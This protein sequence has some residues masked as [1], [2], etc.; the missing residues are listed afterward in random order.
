MQEA[1]NALGNEV[2]AG[3]IHIVISCDTRNLRSCNVAKVVGTFLKTQYAKML[4]INFI[5]A[6]AAI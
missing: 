1:V 5:D 4:G 2:F 3:L 6:F